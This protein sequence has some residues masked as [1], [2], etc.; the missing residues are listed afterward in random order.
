MMMQNYPNYMQ[1]YNYQPNFQPVP[2]NNTIP[3]RIVDDF[4]MISASD[5]PM[6]GDTSVFLKRDLSEIQLRKWGADGRIYNTSYK[7]FVE[8]MQNDIPIGNNSVDIQ[9]LNEQLQDIQ[10]KLDKLL[11]PSTAK[12][13]AA[14]AS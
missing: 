6:N 5:V 7:P 1:P 11:K 9:A 13:V 10:G 8:P 3:G 2:Q 4:S 14:D 12:K